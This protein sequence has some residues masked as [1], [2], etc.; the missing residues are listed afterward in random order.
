ME[1]IKQSGTTLNLDECKFSKPSVRFLGQMVDAEGLQP[2]PE[3]V[4]A[5]QG[6]KKPT[7]VTEMKRFLGLSNQLSKFT[8]YLA[9][10]AKPLRDLL[11]VKNHWTWGDSQRRAFREVKEELSSSPVL[12]LYHPE[13]ETAVSADASSYGLGTVLTQ[14]QP[15]GRW[16]PIAYA[17]RAMTSTEQR[18]AQIEKEVLAITWAC[19]RFSDYLL[20]MRFPVE[21]DH[22]PLVP[23][24]GSKNLEELPVRVQRF[25]MRLM[26]FD[27][28]ISHVPGKQLVIADTLSRAPVPSDL[29]AAEKFG[30]EVEMFVN[31]IVESLP[32]TDKRLLEIRKL[33]DEDEVCQQIKQF[34]KNGWPTR[35]GVKGAI[36]QYLPVSAELTV[37]KG[38]LM[39]GNRIVIPAKLRLEMA[40]Q[41]TH[42]SPRHHKM[43]RKSST[44]SVVAWPQQ[45]VRGTGTQLP[46]VLQTTLSACRTSD[47]HNLPI[48]T[49]AKGGN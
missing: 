6:M 32:A 11:S 36:K 23:L 2:D 13:R 31:L 4:K 29:E 7:N 45:A 47:A 41:V 39:R 43:Q 26:R 18:Y 27:F 49:L 3:K 38:L 30:Q 10:K 17:S 24:L 48:T 21:T 12:A 16:R 35:S 33:Q 34:C 44:I 14:K 8:P 22:K 46:Q 1:R 20:G 37:Q 19:E 9:E 25:R 42:W 40:Q 28:T 5:N 15:D